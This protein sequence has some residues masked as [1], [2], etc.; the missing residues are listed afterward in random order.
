MLQFVKKL[1]QAEITDFHAIRSPGQ[2]GNHK[3]D[4]LRSIKWAQAVLKIKKNC[5][6]LDS[7]TTG[8]GKNDEVVE[9]AIIDLDGNALFNERIKPY[10]KTMP[11]GAKDVHGI[12][13]ADLKD[14][15]HINAHVKALKKVLKRK[16]VIVYNAEY[17]SRLLN[18]SFDRAGCQKLNVNWMCA[19]LWYSSFVGHW[20]KEKES[21]RYQALEGG[22]HSAL[23]DTL[24]TLEVIKMMANA[25][26]S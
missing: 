10:R 22:D 15:E 26:S 13:M 21:Y 12:S 11:K 20:N 16:N 18:Q 14:K 17:D 8:L 25:K 3:K 7:E 24:A 5:V 2:S 4:R 9:L 1:I 19:M 6:I 23:G